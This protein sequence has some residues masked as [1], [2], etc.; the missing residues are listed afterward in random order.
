MIKLSCIYN[1]H[2]KFK[3]FNYKLYEKNIKEYE[4]KIKLDQIKSKSNFI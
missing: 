3:Y 1:H 2:V 4:S